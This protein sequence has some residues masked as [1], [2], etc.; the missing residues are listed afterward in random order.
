V[1]PLTRTPLLLAFLEQMPVPVDWPK[2][3]G[4]P[5]PG[6][7]RKTA[8]PAGAKISLGHK[9]KHKKKRKHRHEDKG[10]P[11]YIAYDDEYPCTPEGKKLAKAHA[12]QFPSKRIKVCGKI[13]RY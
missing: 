1:I 11:G 13:L 10:G 8:Y 5:P 3:I 7:I 12:W 6:V 4:Y 9:K 2:R